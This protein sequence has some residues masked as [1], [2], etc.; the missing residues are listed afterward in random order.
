MPLNANFRKTKTTIIL[1]VLICGFIT[2]T[3]SQVNIH[4]KTDATSEQAQ[5]KKNDDFSNYT[6]AD[7]FVGPLSNWSVYSF[8]MLPI[9]P[10]PIKHTEQIS[11]GYKMPCVQP[12]TGEDMPCL[13]PTGTFPMR[14]FKPKDVIWGILW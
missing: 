10:A 3:Y 4:R 14:V 7:K 1:F 2:P 6:S 5:N 13:K 12:K 11:S 9:G 8:N